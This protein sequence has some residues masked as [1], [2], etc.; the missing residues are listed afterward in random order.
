[1]ATSVRA[2]PRLLR[3][4]A[5]SFVFL[6]F[7][8]LVFSPPAAAKHLSLDPRS[9]LDREK[10]PRCPGVDPDPVLAGVNGTSLPTLV[11]KK[12]PPDYPDEARARRLGGKV[13]LSA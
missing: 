5:G 11:G 13:M 12:T 3:L 7:L 9:G 10:E 8:A 6:S 4:Q 2:T 1:M